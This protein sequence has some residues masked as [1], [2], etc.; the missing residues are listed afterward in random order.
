ML[1]CEVVA[2]EEEQTRVGL[3][4]L[5]VKK[6][7]TDLKKRIVDVDS[8]RKLLVFFLFFSLFIFYFLFFI[9]LFLLAESVTKISGD[10]G[11]Q[12]TVFFTLTLLKNL[13]NGMDVSCLD[14][15]FKGIEEGERVMEVEVED[16]K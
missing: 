13:W 6:E 4:V 11:T 16:R 10:S 14:V 7:N 2:A 8:A 9:F 15:L 3:E 1:R 12:A 5:A